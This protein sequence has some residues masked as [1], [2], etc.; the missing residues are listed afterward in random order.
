[1][2]LC[3]LMFTISWNN[4]SWSVY[5][6]SLGHYIWALLTSSI[7]HCPIV[8]AI[9]THRI[10]LSSWNGKAAGGCPWEE[11]L[12]PHSPWLGQQGLEL[13]P[14]SPELAALA[15]EPRQSPAITRGSLTLPSRSPG[16]CRILLELSLLSVVVGRQKNNNNNNTSLPSFLVKTLFETLSLTAVAARL[17]P[18]HSRSLDAFSHTS[19]SALMSSLCP[20]ASYPARDCSPY[21]TYPTHSYC[22]ICHYMTI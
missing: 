10:L 18:L 9:S 21:L 11:P 15:G 2:K 6:Y 1:M 8:S 22:H 19:P 14:T 12:R 7:R 16:P 4:C 3:T 5:S 17:G 13:G 20:A